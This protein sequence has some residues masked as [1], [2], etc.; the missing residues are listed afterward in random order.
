Q[1]WPRSTRRRPHRGVRSA[2]GRRHD[3]SPRHRRDSR[4]LE[5]CR[6]T[7]EAKLAIQPQAIFVRM[8][9]QG[10]AADWRRACATCSTWRSAPFAPPDS[11]GHMMRGFAVA[12]LVVATMQ[13]SSTQQSL[14]VVGSID[15]PR[16][17]GRI[18]HLA[19]DSATLRLF[20]AAL[21][22]NTV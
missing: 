9:G 11:G 17:E 19:Y 14:T 15:L 8:W 4:G 1:R 5:G 12:V 3:C 13:T 6:P 20:V 18:D 7:G 2:E 21:G 22:N 16:V 10:A